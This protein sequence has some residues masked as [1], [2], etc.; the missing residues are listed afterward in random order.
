MLSAR[1]QLTQRKSAH[2]FHRQAMDYEMNFSLSMTKSR[3]ESRVH[4]ITGKSR[5][6]K[7][8]LGKH[9]N[10]VYLSIMG[11]KLPIRETNSRRY[12]RELEPIPSVVSNTFKSYFNSLI[13]KELD[14]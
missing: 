10:G 14:S 9:C 7:G 12:L 8:S 3:T 13:S 6:T 1:I 5:E 4:G 11:M 2:R